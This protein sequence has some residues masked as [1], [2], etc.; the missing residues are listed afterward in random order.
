[1]KLKTNCSWEHPYTPDPKFNKR[2][3]YF[4]MEFGIHQTL[5]TYSGGLGYLA[6][7]HMQ[8]AHDL[9]Q[10]MIG[11]GMLWKYGYYD[12]VRDHSS[13]MKVLFR[14]RYYNYLQPTDLIFPVEINGHTVH[15][16]V[17]GDSD[18]LRVLI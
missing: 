10:N 6:G 3:A 2:V 7:S 18:G 12:Q 11:I 9:K 14:E 8:A 17:L 13:N 5:K 1:M 4:S 16:H 15:D